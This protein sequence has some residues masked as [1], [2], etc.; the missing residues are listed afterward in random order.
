MKTLIDAISLFP[1]LSKQEERDLLLIVFNNKEKQNKAWKDARDKL[2]NHNIRWVIN[3]ATKY[4]QFHTPLEDR[5]DEG[6]C[7][8]IKAIDRFKLSYTSRL[9]TFAT[10]WIQRFI[11]NAEYDQKNLIRT[12]RYM[13]TLL[14]KYRALNNDSAPCDN[15]QIRQELKLTKKAMK[16]LMHVVNSNGVSTGSANDNN[17]LTIEM[18]PENDRQCV[19]E[20]SEDLLRLK[21]MI[22]SCLDRDREIISRRFGLDGFKPH[23]LEEIG[24]SIGLTRERVRQISDGILN[25]FYERFT[26]K[27][28]TA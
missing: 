8:L 2:V 17:S 25:N 7:G 26:K 15:E 16:L 12:P 28:K 1:P 21:Q 23:T 22:D 3:I 10:A 18:I 4:K 6:V 14:A 27:Q 9:S 13:L 5:I 20:T 11:A 24:E 19:L